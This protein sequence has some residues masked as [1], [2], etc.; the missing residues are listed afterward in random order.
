M[1]KEYLLYIIWVAPTIVTSFGLSRSLPSHSN[2]FCIMYYFVNYLL[3]VYCIVQYL[4][5]SCIS[6]IYIASQCNLSMLFCCWDK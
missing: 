6:V 2:S 1:Y 3:I 5:V 4:Y